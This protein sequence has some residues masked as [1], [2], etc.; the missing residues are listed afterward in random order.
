VNAF[1][2]LP[3][4]AREAML[5]P[6]LDYLARAERRADG[7]WGIWRIANIDGGRNN[8]LYRASCGLG[9][10][11]VKFTIRDERD[12][13]GREFGALT[14]LRQAGLKIASAPL[15]LD[16][17]RYALPVV[18][19]TWLEGD[20]VDAVPASDDD[21]EK[22]VRHLVAVHSVTPGTVDVDLRTA[23][24]NAYN[25]MEGH[26]L[27]REYVAY[28]PPEERPSA[29]RELLHQFEATTLPDWEGKHISLIRLDNNTLNYVR[30]PE[31]WLSVDWENSGWGDPAFDVANL[32]THAAY[33]D[34]PRSR[35]A[36]VAERYCDLSDDATASTR[37]WSYY[38]IMAVW[39][40][41]RMA[42][43]LY[44]MPRGLDTRLV[45]WWREDSRDA[46]LAEMQVKYEWYLGLAEGLLGA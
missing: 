12:R 32:M 4:V 20:V 15:L 30:R 43:Y 26:Q 34:V 7:R 39:W 1:E 24:I 35:W 28:I 44:E 23:T 8:R 22:I 33:L 2:K 9:D 3:A 14:A 38:T 36:W 10:L 31:M 42:R 13:A 41:V 5:R 27:I 17:D 25:V 11:V 29:L 45:E 21:W 18:V 40:V 46:W 37:I 16:C 19:Q 6:L